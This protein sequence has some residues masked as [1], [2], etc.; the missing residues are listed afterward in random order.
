MEVEY[1]LK[2]EV[3]DSSWITTNADG[4]PDVGVPI[5]RDNGQ[6]AFGD[7]VKMVSELTWLNGVPI[8]N[9]THTGYLKVSDGVDVFD[10]TSSAF[11]HRLTLGHTASGSGAIDLKVFGSSRF[12][13]IEGANDAYF[14]QFGA[15]DM[16]FRPA[17]AIESFRLTGTGAVVTGALTVT[18][19][20]GAVGS[21][22]Y[23]DANGK[24]QISPNPTYP[25]I[26][27]NNGPGVHW[28]YGGYAKIGVWDGVDG[29]TIDGSAY[30]VFDLQN[31]PTVRLRINRQ[32]STV[33]ALI[34]GSIRSSTFGDNSISTLDLFSPDS[35]SSIQIY[36]DNSDR[37]ISALNLSIMGS[38]ATFKVGVPTTGN[39]SFV[40]NSTISR[41]LINGSNGS[42]IITP[43]TTASDIG[44]RIDN[45]GLKVDAISTMTT[46]NTQLFAV[47]D[48]V[49]SIGA[50]SRYI[51]IGSGGVQVGFN[52]TSNFSFLHGV[53]ASLQLS[54]SNSNSLIDLGSTG[55]LSYYATVHAFTGSITA[56]R[57][58]IG[59]GMYIANDGFN[60]GGASALRIQDGAGYDLLIGKGDNYNIY[61]S[62]AGLRFNG[63]GAYGIL[64]H[65]AGLYV[66]GAQVIMDALPTSAPATVGQLY[67]DT[68]ANILA[69]GNKIVAIKV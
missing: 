4:I 50:N 8:N 48:L 19:L 13:R 60:L 46:T 21:I 6:M 32:N 67:I 10:F 30:G 56:I 68:A 9:A 5:F 27:T 23:V 58:D 57:T 25:F 53:G 2:L 44:I 20:S 55:N 34:N 1:R 24:L 15:G 54:G 35:L 17:G 26:Y 29:V 49:Y 63:G 39:L 51:D 40:T 16:I 65:G 3:V 22:P 52:T 38:G 37:I 18:N 45:V 42:T 43:S 66:T 33:Q 12:L 69:S 31:N 47:K 62:S 28:L 61:N 59:E 11:T 41:M 64:I 7:N 14:S 36:A